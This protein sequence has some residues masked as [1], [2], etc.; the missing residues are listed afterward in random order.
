MET[1]ELAEIVKRVSKKFVCAQCNHEP[2]FILCAEETV[3]DRTSFNFVFKCHNEELYM[4][5]HDYEI[6]DVF[7]VVASR[8]RKLRVQL[9]VFPPKKKKK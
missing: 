2:D 6:I 4:R 9:M 8:N 1:G 5:L 7:N 3:C